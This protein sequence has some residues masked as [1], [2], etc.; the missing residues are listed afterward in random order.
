MKLAYKP[1]LE[2]AKTYWQ[3]YWNREIIDRP[4]V[5]VTAPKDPAREGVQVPYMAGFRDGGT[6]EDALGL[7]EKRAAS[8]YFGG[9]A[10]PFFEISFGPDQFSGFLGAELIMAEDRRT[11]W[12]KPFVTDWREIELQ[13]DTREH[14]L[15][16]QMLEYVR[17]AKRY[18]E[19]KFLIS[20]ID[21]HSNFDCLGAIRGAEKLCLDVIE[22][23]AEIDR[24]MAQVRALFAPVYEGIYEAGGM[25]E[26]GSIGWAPFYCEGRFATI[27]CDYICLICPEHARRFVIPALEEEASYLDHCVYHLDGPGALPHLDDI[28]ALS[29]A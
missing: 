17:V 20:V 6:Y 16:N 10:I 25:A 28:L 26:R 19:G 29:T 24:M 1:D 9:E 21:I 2:Q 27:Q 23:P 12:V 14:S 13:L 15:W 7:F 8:T 11:S 18:S 3:A 5:V 22:Q 4:C